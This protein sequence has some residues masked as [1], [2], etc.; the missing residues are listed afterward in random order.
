M[1][2]YKSE[3]HV[4]NYCIFKLKETNVHV[5][6]V[7]PSNTIRGLHC[8]ATQSQ[9]KICSKTI[10]RIKSGNCDAIGD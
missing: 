7:D 2:L 6:Y 10:Q 9:S 3:T 5:C 1:C 4:A 8:H